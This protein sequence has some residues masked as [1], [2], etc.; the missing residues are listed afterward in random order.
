MGGGGMGG[1][2]GG[3][4]EDEGLGGMFGGMG[5]VPG[6][7]PGGY[8]RHA[9]ME[10]Q[11]VEVGDGCSSLGSAVLHFL[12]RGRPVSCDCA[13]ASGPR[14]LRSPAPPATLCAVVAGCGAARA[15]PEAACGCSWGLRTPT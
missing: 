1:M 6:G 2:F 11:K 9:P 12:N 13:A 3:D 15:V 14:R 10:P 5:G 8:G 4:A 7:M